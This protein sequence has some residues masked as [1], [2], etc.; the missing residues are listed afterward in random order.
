LE[1]D[2]GNNVLAETWFRMAWVNNVVAQGN[3]KRDRSD[4]AV[5]ETGLREIQK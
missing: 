5:V 1:R 4:L 3:S 2:S